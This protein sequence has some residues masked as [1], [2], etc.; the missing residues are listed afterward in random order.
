MATDDVHRGTVDACYSATM[1]RAKSGSAK[2]ILDALKAGDYF[3]T[4]GP[5]VFAEQKGDVVIVRCTPCVDIRIHSNVVF[6]AGRRYRGEPVTEYEFK[7]VEDDNYL[8][9]EAVDEDG[10][11][12]YTNFIKIDTTL[13][14]DH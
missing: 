11:M 10:R 1:V 2:D 9:I 8:R 12:G 14:N 5:Q 13:L 4:A 3:A 7:L 6:A